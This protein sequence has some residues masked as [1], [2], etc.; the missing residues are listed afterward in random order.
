[1]NVQSQKYSNEMWVKQHKVKVGIQ[2][3]VFL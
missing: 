2:A 1:M 3:N